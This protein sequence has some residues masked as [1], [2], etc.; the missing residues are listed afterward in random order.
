M[1]DLQEFFEYVKIDLFLDV[2]Y[3]FMLKGEICVLLCGVMVLDFVYVVY[4]DLGNQCVV[5]KINNELLLLC[6]ELKNGDI[7]EVVMVLYLKLNLVWFMFVCI[8]KVCVVIW[9]FFKMVK[10]DEVI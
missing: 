3:V 5:V 8:G 1:G 2:V 7:V 9:Y 4:S 6:M 10:L